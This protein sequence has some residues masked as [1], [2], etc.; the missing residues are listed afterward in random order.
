[1]LS[2]RHTDTYTGVSKFGSHNTSLSASSTL[3]TNWV[4]G[5]CSPPAMRSESTTFRILTHRATHHRHRGI[6]ENDTFL[7]QHGRALYFTSLT[8]HRHRITHC[9]PPPC[10]LIQ[11]LCWFTQPKASQPCHVPPDLLSHARVQPTQRSKVK[12]CH[13]LSEQLH[14]EG[15]ASEEKNTNFMRHYLQRLA[16]SSVA[17]LYKRHKHAKNLFRKKVKNVISPLICPCQN[18]RSYRSKGQD[19]SG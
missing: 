17:K 13:K 16:R 9:P 2:I 18:C 15:R 14:Y 12:L 7:G 3:A 8:N 6:H 4:K 1:M 19:A 11:V 5:L 10:Y